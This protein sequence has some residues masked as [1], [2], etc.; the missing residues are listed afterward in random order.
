M[1]RLVEEW[2]LGAL[3]GTRKWQFRAE[4]LV[5]KLAQVDARFAYKPL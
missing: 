5:P 4:S 1:S 2:L 3:N